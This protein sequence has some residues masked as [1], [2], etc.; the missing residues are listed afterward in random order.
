MKRRVHRAF[1]EERNGF[2]GPMF[3]AVCE[4]THVEAFSWVYSSATSAIAITMARLDD[5]R[6]DNDSDGDHDAKH[7]LA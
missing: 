1:V 4:H 5:G 3:V 2:L 7:V 6:C